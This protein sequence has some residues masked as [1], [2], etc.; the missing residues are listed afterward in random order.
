MIIEKELKRFNLVDLVEDLYSFPAAHQ[1]LV[2]VPACME[3][4]QF[5]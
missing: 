4:E 2:G 1:N 3:D 5:F